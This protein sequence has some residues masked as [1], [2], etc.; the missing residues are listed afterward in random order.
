M[1]YCTGCGQGNATA[2]V[3]KQLELAVKYLSENKFEEAI[4]AYQDVI[5]IDPKNIPAYKGMSIAYSFQGKMDKAEQVL[6]DGLNHISDK[7]PLKLVMAGLLVDQGKTDQAEALYNEIIAQDGVY[8]PAYQGY[9][10][11]HI[12]QGKQNEALS[13]LEKGAMANPK[14]YKIHSLLAELYIKNGSRENALSAIAKSLAIEPNQ[15]VAYKLLE[16]L[17][18]DRWEDLSNLADQ[19]INQNQNVP[20]WIIKLT[21]LYKLGKYN[22]VIKIYEQLD[23]DVRKNAKLNIIVARAYTKL[24]KKDQQTNIL[25]VIKIEDVKDAA[26][27]AEI[28]AD[29]LEAGDKDKARKLAVQGI[30]LDDTELDNYIVLY[31]SY[32]EENKQQAEFWLYK[33]LLSCDQSVK[34]AK[35]EQEVRLSNSGEE[36]KENTKSPEVDTTDKSDTSKLNNSNSSKV[37]NEQKQVSKGSLPAENKPIQNNP[38]NNNYITP[39]KA[40]QIAKKLMGGSGVQIVDKISGPNIE[41][42]RIIK[43]ADYNDIY[44]V[45]NQDIPCY[46]VGIYGIIADAYFGEKPPDK[47]TIEYLGGFIIDKRNG[48]VLLETDL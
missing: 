30:G 23:N 46:N 27:L 24:G 17:Y 11:L 7:R 36:K 16:E 5:K 28:A 35:K 48:E 33:H 1:I 19:Y 6:E 4:L 12:R 37:N 45:N 8:L 13:L 9:S 34:E 3:S 21:G 10:K 15:S 22:D 42:Q 44:H 38:G 40:I 39:E 32:L 26:L 41:K 18:Y 47:K 14:Q 43:I 31:K 29:Y 2:E 25:Q 20:G